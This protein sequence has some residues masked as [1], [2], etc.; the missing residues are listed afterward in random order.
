M[1]KRDGIIYREVDIVMVWLASRDFCNSMCPA[2][3]G[4]GGGGGESRG[5]FPMESLHFHPQDGSL[6]QLKPVKHSTTSNILANNK[7]LFSPLHSHCVSKCKIGAQYKLRAIYLTYPYLT[8]SDAIPWTFLKNFSL[9]L[10][11][12]RTIHSRTGFRN[13]LGQNH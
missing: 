4:G 3:N 1:V 8:P 7:V 6:A 5:A 13:I 2:S 11:V 10:Y 9:A 12:I